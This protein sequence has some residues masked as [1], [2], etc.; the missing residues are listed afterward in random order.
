MSGQDRSKPVYHSGFGS[1]VHLRSR[2]NLR[3]RP[4]FSSRAG[5]GSG[6][7]FRTPGPVSLLG[8]YVP[9]PMMGNPGLRLPLMGYPGF[10]LPML[11]L[12]GHLRPIAQAGHFKWRQW[13]GPGLGPP[14]PLFGNY[15]HGYSHVHS[16]P[17]ESF[18]TIK[19]RK[20]PFPELSKADK[21]R[22]FKKPKP[23]ERRGLGRNA[24]YGTIPADSDT[25]DSDTDE[26]TE[27]ND[28]VIKVDKVLTDKKFNVWNLPAKAKVLLVSVLFNFLCATGG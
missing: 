3:S 20:K 22:S 17:S 2:G 14:L 5:S 21:K 4:R 1:R 24:S 23:S 9:P 28:N 13:P 15:G 27:M 11:G 16:E 8:E 10:P 18:Q 12:P 7:R 26:T 6:A 25:D 19:K